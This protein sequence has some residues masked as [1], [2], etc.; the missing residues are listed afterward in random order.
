MIYEIVTESGRH[1]QTDSLFHA[2]IMARATA[3]TTR[4]RVQVFHL[5]TSSFANGRW[6]E[7]CHYEVTPEEADRS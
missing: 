7:T 5:A 1:G 6:G 4:E 3:R 2:K